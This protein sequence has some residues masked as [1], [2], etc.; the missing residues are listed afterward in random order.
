MNFFYYKNKRNVK[1]LLV[2]LIASL[3]CLGVVYSIPKWQYLSIKNVLHRPYELDVYDCDD[4]S[5]DLVKDLKVEGYDATWV[6]SIDAKKGRCGLYQG[7]FE[8]I[9]ERDMF[10]HAW[11]IIKQPKGFIAIE[12]TTG[13]AMT[14]EQHNLFA[15]GTTDGNNE[16]LWAD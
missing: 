1:I 6:M 7:M 12:S 8:K 16:W 11:V 3:I 10:C 15:Y 14:L 5:K 13:F 2:V 9:K 4:F